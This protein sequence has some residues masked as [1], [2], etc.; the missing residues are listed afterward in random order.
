MKQLLGRRSDRTLSR[1]QKTA[2]GLYSALRMPPLQ[3]AVGMVLSTFFAP[4]LQHAGSAEAG[5]N[6][7]PLTKED[8]LSVHEGRFYLE[9]QPFAEISFNKFDLLWQLYDELS[10]GQLLDDANPV[11][12]TQE[13]ALRELHAMG[14]R[15]IRI[16]A[17]PWGPGGP[18]SY[19]DSAKRRLLY[20]ALDKVVALC[21]R[22]AIRVVW[23]LGAGAFTDTKL[24]PGKGWVYGEEHMRE[25]VSDPGSRGRQLLYR[26]IDETV[27]RY[28]H[29]QAVLMWEIGNEITLSADIGNLS[30]NYEGERMPTLKE[31]AEFFNDV[32][33]RIKAA[34]PLRLVSSGGSSMRESQ[35][36]LYQRRSWDKDTFEEQVKCFELLYTSTAVDVIDVH[37]YLNNKPGYIVSDG[38]GGE[39][40]LGYQDWMRIARRINKPLMIGE[41]G[42]HAA[43]KTEGKI[44]EE[45]P[46]YFESYADAMAVKPWIEKTLNRVIDAGIQLAYWWCYQSDRPM[47]RSDPQ[48]FDLTRERN[49]ELLQ[50]M[51]EANQ[52][53]KARLCITP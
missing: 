25:L 43:A 12:Q 48:R 35:W 9:G 10:A 31:V 33:L 15:T 39:A 41:L 14:F 4:G 47:D 6:A 53:L 27:A 50:C 44:W 3:A 30:R 26:Y 19:A 2:L 36:N 21:D 8:V 45:T 16:F 51:M 24:R 38:A 18:E 22:H 52:R 1:L 42:L 29:C 11:V 40:Y 28:Q 7:M 5:A 13:K 20:Q 34:D 49:P 23:S 37:S 46:D 17:L 32:A